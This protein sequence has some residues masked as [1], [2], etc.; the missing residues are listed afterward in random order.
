MAKFTFRLETL[1]K[2]RQAGRDERRAQLAQAYE[3]ERVLQQ[4][5]EDLDRQHQQ[6]VTRVRQASQPGPVNVD[7]LVNSQRHSVVVA[8]QQKWVRRQVEQVVQEI[9]NRRRLLVE[10]DRQVRVLEKL[11]DKQ[12]RRHREREEKLEMK[13]I[14]EIAGRRGSPKENR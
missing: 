14:D 1:L 13:Q 2:L 4:R 5:K 12:S 7:V 6:I 10:A 9:E 8:V 11:R 3:A